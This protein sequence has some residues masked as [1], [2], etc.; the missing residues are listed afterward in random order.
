[1]ALVSINNVGSLGIIKDVPAYQLPP[2][3]WSDGA[4]MRFYVNNAYRSLGYAQVF[5]TPSVVPGFVMNVP[6]AASSFWLYAS[7]AAVY[8][9]D[10][11]THTDIT[12]AAGVYTAAEYRD[13]NG[14]LLGG[15]PILNNFEDVPQYWPTLALGTDLANLSN[16]TST[17]RAKVIRNFG[18]FLVALNL[19]DNGTLLQHAVQWSSQ[20]DP[21][22]V[23]AS[24]DLTDATVDTGR[25]HLTDVKGGPVLD[26]KLLGD[27]LIIYKQ[28]STHA[29]RFIGGND[30]MG[31]ELLFELGLLNTR[32]VASIDGGS[33]HFCVGEDDIFVHSGQ[34]GTPDYPIEERDKQ[35]LFTDMDTTNYV[36]AYVVDNPAYKEAIFAYPTSGQTYPNKA[37]VWNYHKR[38]TTFRDWNGLSSDLGTYTDSLGTTWDATTGSWDA[39]TTAWATQGRKRIISAS[40]ADTKLYGLDSGYAFGSATTTAFLQRLALPVIGRDKSGAMIT[41]FTRRKL[42]SRIWPRIRG[43]AT[44]SVRVGAQE[45]LDGTVTWAPA[46]SFSPSQ[47][48]LDFTVAG[49]L[50]AF[51]FS[52]QSNLAWQVEGYDYEVALLGSH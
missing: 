2:E 11:G 34:K 22:T 10:A 51:E 26:G 18:K 19:N 48:Y 29:M 13:W 49:R 14:C 46:Q 35:Y 43:T 3:A 32:C 36:N 40:P 30:I 24:W 25:T 39:Q 15:I 38:R 28:N 47:Q 45:E 41:D 5:S 6:A 21:G 4:N 12:R 23:P 9:Y 16:W 33:R 44:V 37:L 1:M 52:S 17:L 20:A 42:V 8:G 31:F 50:P 27:R 7:K